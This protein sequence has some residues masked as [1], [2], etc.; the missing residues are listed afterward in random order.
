MAD[1]ALHR[2]ERA[3]LAALAVIVVTIP[4]S[5]LR[6]PSG[7]GRAATDA[8][9]TF[10]GGAGCVECHQAAAEAWRGSDH[11]LAMAE[12]TEETVR[13]NFNNVEVSFHGVTSRFY[14]RDGKFLVWTEGPGGTMAE[15][16][17]AYVFGF[18]PLQQYLIP[19]PGGR[20]QA[21]GL[22]WDVER[23]RW[24]HLYPDQ[25][26]P[27][28]DWLHWT[29]NGQNW[30]GM[31][32]ECHSTNLQKGYH[33][34]SETYTTSWTDIDVNCEACHGPGSRHVAWA[35]VPP[36][37]RPELP[38]LG[39]VVPTAGISPAALVELCAPC[40]SRRAELG[41]W[42]HRGLQLLDHM[43]P[44]L[45]VEGLY[46][47]DGQDLDEVY[48][49]GAFLQSKMYARGVSCRD[50]HDSHG[51]KLRYQGNE[52]CLQC[53]QRE[54]YDSYDH[55]F[56]KKVV[57]GRPS[58]GALCVKCHMVERPYMVIDWRADHSLRLPRPDL[59]AEIGTPNACTQGGC[60]DDRP[61]QWSVD[62]YRRWYGQARR[63][64]YGTT[65][66]A[67][68]RGEPSAVAELARLAGHPLQPAIVRATALELLS[69]Y[70]GAEAAAAVR[71]G[72]A[73]EDPLIRHTAVSNLAIADPAERAA[74]LAPL[75]S[76]PV[77]A[78]RLAALSN[79]AGVPRELLKSYQQEAF[80]SALAEY[81]TAMEYSLDFASSGMNLGN[82]NLSL[83]RAGEAERYYRLA[84][85]IDELFY[86]A[87][88]NLAVLLSGQG[89]NDE[90]E[91]ELREVLAAYPDNAE[92]AY[93][94]GLLLVEMGRPDEGLG[95]L[96]RAAAA[97]PRDARA[98]YN[99]GLL[100][101][102]VGRLDEARAELEQALRIEP[103]SLDLLVALA[104][105]LIRRGLV[106]EARP[107]AERLVALYPD[108]EIGRQLLAFIEG[109]APRGG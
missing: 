65:F 92:A 106:T 109:S 52:L 100:L 91:T 107:L 9:P 46:F 35:R 2:W 43:L 105:H 67:A 18:E 73:A 40:H 90:A 31:C 1:P 54:V 94:L 12:A 4:L 57:E 99:L 34:D 104:D 22:A 15:F 96:E 24:Y 13:G 10:V 39:L 7:A 93:S 25:D 62:A 97:L 68:R 51:L 102:K 85:A 33:P 63:P 11:D 49:Y 28:D 32:A 108:Q 98:H 84:L 19:F 60:H 79:L 6:G 74:L 101:Q 72:V 58:D 36:M 17:V 83:G 27:A 5:L 21:L 45:L 66:A 82:L 37:A 103:D 26:I 77:K 20:L 42:D 8:T 30:N 70:P 56:H 41:D 48:T 78:V 23:R 47:A 53:H 16:E 3:G 59:T 44:S 29:R 88:M 95:W 50:C 38:D 55:H 61:L 76:D 64:H 71:A 81:R 14:R 89:R 69:A 75:L 86:P 80:D 87:R